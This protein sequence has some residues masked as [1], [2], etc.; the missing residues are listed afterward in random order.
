MVEITGER[1]QDIVDR[2]LKLGELKTQFVFRWH[3]PFR[4]CQ[5]PEQCYD[6]VFFFV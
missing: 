1:M 3:I 6:W 2:K 5:H 4:G